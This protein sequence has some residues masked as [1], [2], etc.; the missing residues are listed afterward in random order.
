[1]ILRSLWTPAKT[2]FPNKV[3]FAGPRGEDMD[4]SFGGT[5]FKPLYPCC[6]IY[7]YFIP[8]DGQ[9]IFYFMDMP[10]LVCPFLSWWTFTLFPFFCCEE[11]CWEPL[12]GCMF[13]V[14]LSIYLEADLPSLEHVLSI[15]FK[16]HSPG[17]FPVSPP[18]CAKESSCPICHSQ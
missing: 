5:P 14:L 6:S 4:A 7:Q 11:C 9:I 3:T 1:M 8:F 12:C 18:L 10:R 13:S 17:I 15:S 2:L 16:V